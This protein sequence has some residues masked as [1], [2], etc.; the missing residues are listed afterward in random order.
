MR[1]TAFYIAQGV[2]V[3]GQ[4]I[5]QEGLAGDVFL[6]HPG[7]LQTFAN[8]VERCLLLG[9]VADLELACG[10]RQRIWKV[11]GSHR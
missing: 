6:G 5:A 1:V 8:T 7:S 3:G 11:P 2:L 10:P 9:P 4:Y